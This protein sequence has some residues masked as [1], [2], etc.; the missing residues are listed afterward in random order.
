MSRHPL[1]ITIGAGCLL[2]CW[3]NATVGA[4]SIHVDMNTDVGGIQASR[5]IASGETVDVD[6]V[7]ETDGAGISAYAFSV[8]YDSSELRLVT[9]VDT[10]VAPL[11]SLA[12]GVSEVELDNEFTQLSSFDGVTFGLGPADAL[13]VAGTLTFI[14]LA[15]LEDGLAPVVDSQAR[16]GR[17]SVLGRRGRSH[18]TPTISKLRS[19]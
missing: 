3:P 4:I 15:P 2:L 14:A 1:A 10:P 9:A 19:R 7:I 6:I 13:L 12:A 17:H 18:R 8:Q 16:N 5:I 11:M